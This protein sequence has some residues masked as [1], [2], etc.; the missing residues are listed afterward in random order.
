M[1][2]QNRE[3]AENLRKLL[4]QHWLHCRHLE[5]ER[6]WFMSIYAAI[7]GGV[8]AF[9]AQT[10]FE[11]TW[12][13]YFLVMLTFFGFFHTIRWIY[14]FECHRAK[15]NEIARVIW[16]ESKAPADIDPT[17]D[18]PAMHILPESIWKKKT[19]E[20]LKRTFNGIFRTR[21]WFPLFYLVILVGLVILSFTV[22]FPAWGQGITIAALVIAFLLG[23]GWYF[24]LKEI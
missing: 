19:P 14:A 1:A 20:G 24:S 17:M 3:K 18:I 4:E 2:Q 5:S 12:P 13:L 15:V 10:G 6:A 8:L 23:V 7:T 16:S 21:Y 11:L 22:G 9:T